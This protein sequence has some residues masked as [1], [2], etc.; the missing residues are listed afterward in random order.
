L[1]WIFGIALFP[2]D[3]HTAGEELL[4][5]QQT[6]EM[7]TSTKQR[8][9]RLRDLFGNASDLVRNLI[10]DYRESNKYFKTKMW[11]IV[12]YAFI[13]ILSLVVFIPAGETNEID[14]RL[15]VAKASYI[16]GNYFLVANESSDPW[17]D[18]V[19]TINHRFQYR[20]PTLAAGKKKMFYF[21]KFTDSSGAVA[22]S[23]IRLQTVSIEC[24]EGVF[25]RVYK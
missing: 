3:G 15:S 11:L 19:I 23:D 13:C 4:M 12:L 1:H 5:D 16:G 6:G 20:H 2:W 9:G 25:E 10:D 14:A 17:V 21:N 7:K 18:V 22:G 8:G 24:N